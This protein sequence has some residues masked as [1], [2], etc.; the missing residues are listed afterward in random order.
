MGKRIKKM[1]FLVRRKSHLTLLTIGGVMV[2]LLFFNEE[3]SFAR[4]IEYDARIKQLKE[5]IRTYRDSAAYFRRHREALTTDISN[6]EHL[7]REK[8][9]MQRPTEDVFLLTTSEADNNTGE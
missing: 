7:A 5:D 1:N 2:L 9:H 8:Y 4:N 3:T 6:L